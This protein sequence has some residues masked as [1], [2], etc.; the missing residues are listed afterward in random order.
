[1]IEDAANIL[2][3]DDGTAASLLKVLCNCKRRHAIGGSMLDFENSK[4]YFPARIISP[5]VLR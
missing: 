4:C 3:T 1:M 5:A 2:A